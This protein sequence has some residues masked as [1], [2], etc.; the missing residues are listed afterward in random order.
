MKQLADLP[1]ASLPSGLPLARRKRGRGLDSLR[2]WSAYRQSEDAK[3]LGLTVPP[4]IL[5]RT[6]EVVE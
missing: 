5:A 3:A 6:D 1:N 4:S 2:P